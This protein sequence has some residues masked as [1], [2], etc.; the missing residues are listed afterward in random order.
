MSVSEGQDSII[1]L[2]VGG[3]RFTTSRSTLTGPNAGSLAAWFDA[4]PELAPSLRDKD[5]SYFIDRSP[6]HF[7][8]ILNFLRDGH[9]PLP[10]LREE[11]AELRSEANFFNLLGKRKCNERRA[12]KVWRK[13]R[14]EKDE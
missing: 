13:P 14:E 2:N 9:V 7:D 1:T 11:R 3:R 10:T 12:G 8:K 4:D 5:G 6:K